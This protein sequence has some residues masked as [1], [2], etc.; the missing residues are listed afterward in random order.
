MR[1]FLRASLAAHGYRLV[2]A[3]TARRGARAGHQPQPRTL[4]LLDLGL[5]DGDGVELTRRLREWTRDADHRASRR[6]AARR[7]RSPA[8]DAGADD[9]LTKPFGVGRAARA[10]ARRAA[11]RRSGARGAP[12]TVS[13]SGRCAS[14][15]A[16]REVTRAA[17]RCT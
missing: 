16:R 4:V 17:R 3:A 1:R 13:R 7:T 8:L 11:P 10:H 12:A 5:P 15:S 14:T 9:Y 2:E 6:A